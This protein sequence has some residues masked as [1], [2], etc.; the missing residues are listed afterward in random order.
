MQGF[1]PIT[2]DTLACLKAAIIRVPRATKSKALIRF[3]ISILKK[4]CSFFDQAQSPSASLAT[5]Y[6]VPYKALVRKKR[7]LNI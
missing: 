1:N 4:N 2:M 3:P 6:T 7:S 5:V